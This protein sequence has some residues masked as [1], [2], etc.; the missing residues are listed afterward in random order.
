MLRELKKVVRTLLEPAAETS[1]G[2][3]SNVITIVD[4]KMEQKEDS[5]HSILSSQRWGE[6]SPFQ[7]WFVLC[8][9]GPQ[10]AP[11]VSEISLNLSQNWWKVPWKSPF[12]LQLT[13]GQ[14]VSG[15]WC[16]GQRS[17]FAVA[18]TAWPRATSSLTSGLSFLICTMKGN[19]SAYF[20]RIKLINSW[21]VLETVSNR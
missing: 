16:L 20:I 11:L 5:I 6:W 10:A 17:V 3:K 2:P 14:T 19:K 4:S 13:D 7:L 21:K 15:S 9:L 8:L 18:V 12:L 1:R